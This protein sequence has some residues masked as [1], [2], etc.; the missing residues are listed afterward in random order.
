MELSNLPGSQLD[1]QPTAYTS[2]G[3]GGVSYPPNHS[4]LVSSIPMSQLGSGSLVSS[5]PLRVANRSQLQSASLRAHS[6]VE[7]KTRERSYLESQG[8]MASE[9]LPVASTL[10]N[11]QWENDP[12][13][14]CLGHPSQR[15]E[16]EAEVER[17]MKRDQSSPYP[18]VLSESQCG[19]VMMSEED[20]ERKAQATH[21]EKTVEGSIQHRTPADSGAPCDME[22]FSLLQGEGARLEGQQGVL[23]RRE[24][25]RNK[26][27]CDADRVDEDT[28][29]SSR[30]RNRVTKYIL[31]HR[32]LLE[33]IQD[34][35]RNMDKNTQCP[36][37][38]KSGGE[39][40]QSV[41]R[42]RGDSIV[43]AEKRSTTGKGGKPSLGRS[44][45]SCD[46]HALRRRSMTTSNGPRTESKL[47]GSSHPKNHT[48]E[49]RRG[50]KAKPTAKK[51]SR[52]TLVNK[53]PPPSS[54]S[55]SKHVVGSV[56]SGTRDRSSEGVS[57]GGVKQRKSRAPV[58][59]EKTAA[60]DPKKRRAPT[61]HA[62]SDSLVLETERSLALAGKTRDLCMASESIVPK[63]RLISS[64][65]PQRQ[66]T[67][68][69]P[70]VAAPESQGERKPDGETGSPSVPPHA[71]EEAGLK[72]HCVP[73]VPPKV[74]KKFPPSSPVKELA[75]AAPRAVTAGEGAPTLSS[76]LRSRIDIARSQMAE[77]TSPIM[78]HEQQT[79]DR[80]RVSSGVDPSKSSILCGLR[81]GSRPDDAYPVTYAPNHRGFEAHTIRQHAPLPSQF[82]QS[83]PGLLLGDRQS[84]HLERMMIRQ[85]S[86]ARLMPKECNAE[87]VASIG[88]FQRVSRSLEN[89]DVSPI[90]QGLPV[91][92]GEA[93]YYYGAPQIVT[94]PSVESPGDVLLQKRLEMLQAGK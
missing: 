68:S 21:H 11:H 28:D 79:N 27:R 53:I 31:Q 94:Q 93:G 24:G 30:A 10:L 76:T 16:D 5:K 61:R 67:P 90:L 59:K 49:T 41:R 80:R 88:S 40:N 52:E 44:S 70:Q 89:S 36:E 17:V 26:K 14:T 25:E 56:G 2:A 92:S 1:G 74:T 55:S 71:M 64:E 37:K 29:A 18:L 62:I 66:Q 75:P 33:A 85:P 22:T 50:T 6:A 73:Y 82:Y 42:S 20:M 45:M 91:Q 72:L 43:K 54:L 63:G 77:I 23:M 38:G 3:P 15:S 47:K 69:G 4:G 86:G 81:L 13:G 84:A 34:E 57:S 78:T 58:K 8:H 83:D 87:E 51:D 19:G 35:L 39:G 12:R 60:S 9:H 7:T 46:S 48:E 32:N 65:L